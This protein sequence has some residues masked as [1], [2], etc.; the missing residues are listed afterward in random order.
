M[1]LKRYEQD[2]YKTRNPLYYNSIER[3]HISKSANQKKL[4]RWG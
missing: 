2:K 4:L 1:D 3:L